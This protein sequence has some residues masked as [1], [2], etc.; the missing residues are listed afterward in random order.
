MAN[1]APPPQHNE[2]DRIIGTIRKNAQA[3]SAVSLRMFK[4]Y[5]LSTP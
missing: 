2:P 4:G 1:R 5:R 3:T